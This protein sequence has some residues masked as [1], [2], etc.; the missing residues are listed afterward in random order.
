MSVT[1]S[2]TQ[3]EKAVEIIGQLPPE[4]SVK[5]NQGDQLT[6][7]GLFKQAREGDNTKPKPGMLDFTGK[8]K[9]EAWKKNEG[10]DQE[11][12]KSKYVE[13]FVEFLDKHDP[14]ETKK[15]KDAVLA[16]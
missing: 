11:T 7:Y 9:W 3:F 12:A 6:F 16:A 1:Y 15:H 5:P 8:A 10:L 4:G 13:Y 14:E 2:S